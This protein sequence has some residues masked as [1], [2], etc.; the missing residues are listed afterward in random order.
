MY[1]LV[2]ILIPNYNKAPYLRQTLDSVLSQTYPNWECIIVDDHSTENSWEI[3]KKYALIDTRIKIF[4]RPENRK[5]GGNAARNYAF[6]LSQGE[7]INW[8]D[9]DDIPDKMML[10]LKLEAFGHSRVSQDFVIG[11]VKKF[12]NEISEASDF[13]QLDYDRLDSDLALDYVKGVFWFQTAQPLF[14][15]SYLEKFNKLFDEELL[16]GQE[17]EFFT[18]IL[19]SNPKF[20][21]KHESIIFWRMSED[22]KTLSYWGASFPQKYLV[23]YLSYKTIFLNFLNHRKELEEPVVVFFRNVFNDMLLFLPFNSSEFWDLLHFGTIHNLFKGRFQGA[24][25]LGIRILKTAKLI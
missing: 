17:A 1:P 5:K 2:S 12:K 11:G 9:S 15:K 14:R 22:S 19:L 25:I 13:S 18:R 24:K 20:I 10:E 6:E 21:F 3:L 8:L 16:K 4:K 7:Y 23:S